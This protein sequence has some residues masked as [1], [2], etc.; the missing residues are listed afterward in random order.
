M[1]DMQEARIVSD[2]VHFNWA[3]LAL[4]RNVKTPTNWYKSSRGI[5]ICFLR[6]AKVLR[7]PWLPSS[8]PPILRWADLALS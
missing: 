6:N 2:I 4:S 5:L 3:N 7:R 8:F 1:A